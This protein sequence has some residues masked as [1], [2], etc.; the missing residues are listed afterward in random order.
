MTR[1]NPDT[2]EEEKKY[3]RNVRYMFPKPRTE[4]NSREKNKLGANKQVR[5]LFDLTD[6]NEET[7]KVENLCD[8]VDL[9]ATDYNLDVSKCEV[10]Q[11]VIKFTKQ[12]STAFGKCPFCEIKMHAS[13]FAAHVDKCR[14][15]QQKVLFNLKKF[16]NSS[17]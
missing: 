14:G 4:T 2:E 8:V 17:R 11:I 13:K 1:K 9:D 5:E 12:P 3:V 15:Y 7:A 16:K 6:E 10:S